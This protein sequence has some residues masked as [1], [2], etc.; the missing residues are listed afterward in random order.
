MSAPAI[1]VQ[2]PVSKISGLL[3]RLAP[4]VWQEKSVHR[5]VSALLPS[6]SGV[7]SSNRLSADIA[8]V[9]PAPVASSQALQLTPAMVQS[10]VQLDE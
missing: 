8:A 1:G 9:Q 2:L 6:T 5:E 3:A 10:L 4:Q 7:R